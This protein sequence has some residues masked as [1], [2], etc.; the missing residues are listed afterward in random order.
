M[1]G[2][3]GRSW[4]RLAGFLSQGRRRAGSGEAT[5]R[6]RPG[7]PRGRFPRRAPNALRPQTAWVTS[8]RGSSR[9]GKE[10]RGLRPRADPAGPRRPGPASRPAG[11][12]GALGPRLGQRGPFRPAWRRA[13]LTVRLRARPPQS[14]RSVPVPPASPAG[15]GSSPPAAWG[16]RGGGNGRKGSRAVHAP[17]PTPTRPTI[18]G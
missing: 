18:L 14:V 17:T 11:L 1:G 10:N 16:G 8:A 13:G 6:G 2:G 5:G 12:V 15:R 9:S 4:S 3:E 7:R